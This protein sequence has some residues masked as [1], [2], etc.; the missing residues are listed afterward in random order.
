MTEQIYKCLI[1]DDE[2][3][4]R[5]ILMHFV[6]RVP[7]LVCVATCKTAYEALTQI[8]SDPSIDLVFL[9]INMPNLSGVEMVK[10][11]T[12]KPQIIFTTAYSEYAVE[13][14]ELN[15]ADYLLK[16][17]PYERFLK[18]VYKA[19]DRITHEKWANDG[20][21]K[22]ASPSFY[23]K[24]KGEN[25]LVRVS[26]IVYCEASKNYTMIYLVDGRILHPQV[27][28]S[29]LETDLSA[30]SNQFLR[31]HRSFLINTSFIASIGT[32][33][34]HLNEQKVPIG[35]QY[36]SMVINALGMK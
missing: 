4:A 7:N 30:Q 1:V 36:K 35:Y 23:V 26:D 20:L 8:T 22:A 27:A 18:A 15:A 25:Y 14:Y 21:Q 9:D 34:I 33:Y 31:I 24:S 3:I 12:R 29:K 5:N 17:F 32:D 19:I 28:I 2:P 6:E 10:S 13:S 11:L 16:P